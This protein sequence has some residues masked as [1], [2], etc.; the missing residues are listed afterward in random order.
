MKKPCLTIFISIAAISLFTACSS[1][2][3]PDHAFRLY[4]EDGVMIA[5]TTGGPRYSGELFEYEELFNLEQDESRD[6]TLLSSARSAR[7]DDEGYFFVPDGG[8]DRI[9]VFRPD[10]TYSHSF[11][12]EGEGPGEFRSVGLLGFIDDMIMV[13]DPRLLRTLLFHKDGSF[14][15][16]F[17]FPR[18]NMI[19]NVFFNTMSAWP[20]PEGGSILL[21]QGMGQSESGPIITFRAA[22][23]DA[24][25][26][27]LTDLRTPQSALPRNYEG[28]SMMH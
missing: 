28:L 6:E 24:G 3:S 27:V 25:G 15:R 8:N 11:G 21:Q 17:G 19:D 2:V 26:E 23:L 5:E 22:V 4:E 13:V 18:V 1:K 16:S 14:I 20:G 12:R 9:A 7:M 10:G